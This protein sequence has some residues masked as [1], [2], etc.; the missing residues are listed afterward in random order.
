VALFTV[1]AGVLG[2]AVVVPTAARA[3]STAYFNWSK[4][5]VGEI[6]ICSNSTTACSD[7]GWIRV[8]HGNWYGANPSFDITVNDSKSDGVG[9]RV[10]FHNPSGG[11]IS[12]WPNT[13]GCGNPCT[14][15]YFWN[16]IGY[17][18]SGHKDWW[19]NWASSNTISE[20]WPLDSSDTVSR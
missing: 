13:G 8:E 7:L 20:H 4:Y 3:A 11:Y 2:Q 1:I 6:D 18:P 17:N 15:T 10:V 12:V 19:A 9:P 14:K 5:N 16:Q